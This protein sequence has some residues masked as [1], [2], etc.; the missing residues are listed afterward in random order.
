MSDSSVLV[1]GL[2]APARFRGRHRGRRRWLGC[3]GCIGFGRGRRSRP[4]LFLLDLGGGRVGQSLRLFLLDLGGGRVGQSLRLFLLD[5][6]GGRVGQSLRL[7][8]GQSLLLERQLTAL[9]AFP[10]KLV[11]ILVHGERVG[12][13][14]G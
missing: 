13:L 12:T 2:F 14:D 6:G 3:A 10:D 1:N 5:L 9:H 4:S 8:I 7:F 11:M